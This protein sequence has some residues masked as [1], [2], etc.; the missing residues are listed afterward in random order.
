MITYEDVIT[1]RL[2]HTFSFFTS[3][4]AKEES[5]WARPQN[6]RMVQPIG[7]LFSR[8]IWWL[9]CVFVLSLNFQNQDFE[10]VRFP[11][12]GRIHEHLLPL[13]Q[14]QCCR[15]LKYWT[16]M[17]YILVGTLSLAS[18][19]ASYRVSKVRLQPTRNHVKQKSKVKKCVHYIA[20][21]LLILFLN[22]LQLRRRVKV[23]STSV[24]CCCSRLLSNA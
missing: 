9:L 23:A 2:H 20:I 15:L 6:F 12:N 5:F 4:A 18:Q 1:Q 3:L 21:V 10:T 14:S 19:I 24:L 16:H 8:Q 11:S 17:Y 13:G 7:Y 22:G